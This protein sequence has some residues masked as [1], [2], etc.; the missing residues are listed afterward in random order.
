MNRPDIARLPFRPGKNL[1]LRGIES[2]RV[3]SRLL[4][5]EGSGSQRPADPAAF[6]AAPLAGKTVPAG[7][8]AGAFP[9]LGHVHESPVAG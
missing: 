5:P 2:A 8:L 7:M 6:V 4:S 9:A 3:T 1:R